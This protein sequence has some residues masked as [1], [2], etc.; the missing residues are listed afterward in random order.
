MRKYVKKISWFCLGVNG[1]L[2][3]PQ[4]TSA[5]APSNFKGV[6]LIVVEAIKALLPVIVILAFIYFLW[7]LTKYLK[8]EENRKGDAK[9]VMFRGLIVFF[10]I[11]GL[12]GI[13]N[14]LTNTFIP[15]GG[16]HLPEITEIIQ[17][18]W[19]KETPELE[20]PTLKSPAN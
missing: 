12:W 1:L 7:G 9:S 11:S 15:T 13:I 19:S 8:S 5:S 10:V 20:K 16:V 17:I 3:F 4:I 18:D 6:V 14:I 2:F